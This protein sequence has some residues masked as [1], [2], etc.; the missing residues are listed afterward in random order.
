MGECEGVEIDNRER[1]QA[2]SVV[3]ARMRDRRTPMGEVLSVAPGEGQ[4]AVGRRLTQA[5]IDLEID[6]SQD[7]SAVIRM[8]H[9]PGITLALVQ[10][11]V[12]AMVWRRDKISAGRAL[13]LATRMGSIEAGQEETAIVRGA[14]AALVLPGDADVRIRA[15]EASNEFIVA[16]C[17]PDLLAPGALELAS[18]LEGSALT[19]AKIAP[20][21]NFIATTSMASPDTRVDLLL[22]YCMPLG[23]PD[24]GSGRLLKLLNVGKDPHAFGPP[25]T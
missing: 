10:A 1:D 20:L 18:R 22:I 13:L 25:V 21:Y 2:G 6:P 4:S 19:W 8:A 12:G 23:V 24:V 9:F 5:S 3:P 7:R 14:R 17:S 11:P 16:V 15:R